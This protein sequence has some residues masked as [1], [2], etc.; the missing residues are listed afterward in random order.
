MFASVGLTNMCV[1]VCIQ[2]L[3]NWEQRE[4]KKSREYEKEKERE[5]E[6][7]AEEVNTCVCVGH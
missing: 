4:R 2:R 1:L 5:E 6:R 7:K 3:K